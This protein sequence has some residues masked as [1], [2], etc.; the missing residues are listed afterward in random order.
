MINSS[1]FHNIK[2]STIILFLTF[3]VL[4]QVH[5]NYLVAAGYL[6]VDFVMYS[7]RPLGQ[8]HR[9]RNHIFRLLPYL[10]DSLMAVNK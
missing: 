10:K 8:I 7:Y 3:A 4:L 6:V 2:N 5:L 9:N 1:P